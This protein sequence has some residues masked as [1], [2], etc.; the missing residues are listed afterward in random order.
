MSINHVPRRR[1]LGIVGVGAAAL[2]G[3]AAL[4]TATPAQAAAGDT[5]GFGAEGTIADS[6]IVVL[7]DGFSAQSSASL[8]KRYNAQI[9][10]T[11]KAALKGYAAKM[12]EADARRTAADPAV[13]YVE[14]DGVASIQDT[15]LNPPNWGDDRIDQRDLPLDQSYTYPTTASNVT[16]YILDTGIRTS[17]QDFGGRAT[18]GTNTTGDGNNSDC[19]SH[20]THVAGTV[21]GNVYGVAKGVK[22]IAVKVLNCQGSGSWSGIISGIDWVTNHHTSGPAV[23]NM[24]LGGS[25]SNSS[26]ENA[27]RN[28]INDG[29]T[30]ALAAGNSNSDA[31]N[32]TPART[33]EAIT[34]GATKINDERP[35]DWS[36]GQ[37]SNYGTCLD[38][39]AP[40]DDIVSTAH[41]SDTGSSTKSGTSMASPHVAGAAALHLAANPS[42]TN[43]QVRDALV[44]NSTSG[45]VI[46]PGSG[47]PNKLLFIGG[48]DP[49]PPPPPTGCEAT[50]GADVAISD[51]TTVNSPITIS[52]CTGN[53]SATATVDVNIQHTY[54]GDLTVSLVA[55]DGTAYTLHNRAGGSADNIVKTYTVDL[56]SEAAN[57]TWNL[58]V[59]DAASQDV[60]KI[61]TWT[62]KLGGGTTP[63]PPADCGGTNGTDVAISDHTTVESPITVS[64]CDRAPSATSTVAVNIQHTYIGDLVVALVAPDGTVYTL[65]NRSGGSADNII[66][67]YT[68]N[69]SGEAAN[70]TWKLRVTDAAS[71]DVGKIDTW[72]LTL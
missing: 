45:K 59:N 67:T 5:R 60:G 14:Q 18:W 57:G 61:D 31:C 63:P 40:G 43:Q 27:V 10:H 66:K 50:N 47:S 42:A 4:A 68:V 58:R 26:L 52:D 1:L 36:N 35:T 48:G 11:Y 8:A 56:S 15:Q 65:Q 62:L 6:Y 38:I 29:I 71:Q 30:Y 17:H 64:G 2:L 19:N 32:F 22:L 49:P 16:A 13:A 23:A 12:S 21:G 9:R 3:A 53:A 54:I 28:S 33:P 41:S 69:L 39:F 34:V 7:K 25:G 44:N 46:N 37:G 72:T 55:P 51:H 20:G 24:S 70:G